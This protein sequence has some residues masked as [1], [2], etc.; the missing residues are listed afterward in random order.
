LVKNDSDKS[1]VN[2]YHVVMSEN[3]FIT[4]LEFNDDGF[5]VVTGRHKRQT[6]EW[7]LVREIIA[8]RHDPGGEDIMTLGIRPSAAVEYIHINEDM[9]DYKQLLERMY[10]AIPEIRRDWWCDISASF[11]P[12]RTTIY[13]LSVNDQQGPSPAERYLQNKRRK[14]PSRT[15]LKPKTILWIVLTVVAIAAAQWF[16]AWL[17][18]RWSNV[19]GLG[20]F[21]LVLVMLVS[22]TWPNPRFFIY[23]LIAFNVTGYLLR[24]VF[25]STTDRKSVV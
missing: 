21:P 14:N 23:L 6:V 11:G 3:E 10:E 13:G 16:V 5:A 24:V 17:L 9:P 2:V 20:L 12:N 15:K 7:D 8:Y 22:R 4:H 18:C 1:P 25:A 19:V